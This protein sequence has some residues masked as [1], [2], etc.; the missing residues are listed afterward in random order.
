MSTRHRACVGSG[1]TFLA[2]QERALAKSGAAEGGYRPGRRPLFPSGTGTLP[3]DRSSATDDR[4]PEHLP[5]RATFE[6]HTARNRPPH[7]EGEDPEHPD[8]R[9]SDVASRVVGVDNAAGASNMP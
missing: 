6:A 1:S 8:E 9:V 3:E 5:D 2:A 4:P 7:R